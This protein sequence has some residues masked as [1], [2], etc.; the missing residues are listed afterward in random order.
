M[1]TRCQII[2]QDGNN[3]PY[4]VSFYRHSDGYPQGEHG[5]LATLVPFVDAFYRNRGWD[6]CYMMAQLA[7]NQFEK[8]VMP[9]NQ[10]NAEYYAKPENLKYAPKGTDPYK[11]IGYGIESFHGD[12]HG[13]LAYIYV[14]RR[15]GSKAYVD[16]RSPS[17]GHTLRGSKLIGTYHLN[18]AGEI[19]SI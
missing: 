9:Q 12:F 16:V 19:E 13:D 7:F 5:V 3:K 2:I 4:D 11:Y 8:V 14:I 1:S 15:D 10:R 18:A 17:S 6:E